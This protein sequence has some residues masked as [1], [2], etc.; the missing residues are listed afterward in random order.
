MECNHSGMN[1][2]WLYVPMRF[3]CAPSEHLQAWEMEGCTSL[4]KCKY[5]SLGEA[6]QISNS[7]GASKTL[8]FV[9]AMHNFKKHVLQ[10][11]PF[12]LYTKISHLP[13]A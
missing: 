5:I 11:P 12:L 6:W 1:I 2:E 7:L 9:L 4:H 13:A 8:G 10:T 3:S